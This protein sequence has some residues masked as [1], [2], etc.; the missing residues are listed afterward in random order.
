MDDFEIDKKKLIEI[1]N[2]PLFVQ[3]NNKKILIWPGLC[4]HEGAELK[5]D[6]FECFFV[7]IYFFID[8]S[9]F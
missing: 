2:I 8:I 7:K 6:Y 4:P 9:K 5:K 1:N 3:R